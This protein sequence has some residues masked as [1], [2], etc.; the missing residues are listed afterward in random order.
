MK[1]LQYKR[2]DVI[3]TERRVCKTVTSSQ[4]QLSSVRSAVEDYFECFS[5]YKERFTGDIT[6]YFSGF[7]YE[8]LN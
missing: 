6:D 4:S 7:L 1:N 3:A 2:D 8:L 5:E